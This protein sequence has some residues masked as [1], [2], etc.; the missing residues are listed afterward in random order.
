MYSSP[1]S[2]PGIGEQ[3]VEYFDLDVDKRKREQRMATKH[4]RPKPTRGEL[5]TVEVSLVVKERDASRIQEQLVRLVADC[6]CMPLGAE[7]REL[8][9]QEWERVE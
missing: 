1:P 9:D 7:A 8:T 2:P 4:K 6:G 5:R 3:D